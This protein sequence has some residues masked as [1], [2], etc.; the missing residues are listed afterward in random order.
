MLVKEKVD[1]GQGDK[2]DVHHILTEGMFSTE[3]IIIT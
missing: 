2:A 1:V 3:F